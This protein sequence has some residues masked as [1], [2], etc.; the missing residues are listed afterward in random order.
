MLA[1]SEKLTAELRSAET[2]KRYAEK[3]MG[4]NQS[5]AQPKRA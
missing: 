1:E 4:A 5:R 3:V 2:I